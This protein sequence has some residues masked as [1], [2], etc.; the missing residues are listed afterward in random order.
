[1]LQIKLIRAK[2]VVAVALHHATKPRYQEVPAT[3]D[4]YA[5]CLM[6]KEK[7]VLANEREVELGYIL[8][9]TFQLLLNMIYMMFRKLLHHSQSQFC[10]IFLKRKFNNETTLAM[11]EVS[12]LPVKG[13][14][15]RGKP[16]RET[17]PATSPN[18]P[19]QTSGNKVLCKLINQTNHK[20]E[21]L[22]S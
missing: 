16:V 8:L 13:L 4:A 3:D 9:I 22:Q 20:I 11:I 18:L 10:L 21:R 1:M 2:K 7:H 17:T 19:F 12:K 5:Y 6:R 15:R 14:G